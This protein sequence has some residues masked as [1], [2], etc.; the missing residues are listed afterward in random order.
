M[1]NRCAKIQGRG[2]KVIKM[3][4]FAYIAYV[5]SISACFAWYDCMKSL[6]EAAGFFH[7]LMLGVHIYA[8]VK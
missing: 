2:R 3:Y 8:H 7:I 6:I 4:K 5:V 1:S